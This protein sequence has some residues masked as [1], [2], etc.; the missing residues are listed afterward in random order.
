MI[1]TDLM[2]AV[3]LGTW[4]LTLTE[5][6]DKLINLG[7]TTFNFVAITGVATIVLSF[8]FYNTAQIA[9]K[10]YGNVV[11]WYD[12]VRYADIKTSSMS[13]KEEIQKFYS[14]MAQSPK[15]LSRRDYHKLESQYKSAIYTK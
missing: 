1:L 6:K 14:L 13:Q 5:Y 3:M 8:I 12:D 11:E 15:E 2:A 9:V 7:K 10:D 4:F